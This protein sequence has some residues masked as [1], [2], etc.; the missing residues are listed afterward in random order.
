M[1]IHLFLSPIVFA[2]PAYTNI[3][4]GEKVEGACRHVDSDDDDQSLPS[5][6]ST[7]SELSEFTCDEIS[8]VELCHLLGPAIPEDESK[9]VTIPSGFTRPANLEHSIK[10]D[11]P[12]GFRRIRKAFLNQ[13][14]DFWDKKVLSGT[15]KYKNIA[16]KGW[17]R[18]SDVIGSPTVPKGLKYGDIVG[19]TK[20]TEYLMPKTALVKANMAY[21][22]TT[23]TAYDDHC[24]AIEMMTSNPDVPFGK[25]FIA[26]TKIVVYN[27][28]ANSCV[29]ECSVE[30][31]FPNGPPMAISRQIKHAMKTGSIEVFEKIGS[32]IKNCAVSYGW[33]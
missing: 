18:H 14:N 5:L 27:T 33:V 31:V 1:L 30:T 16:S 10:I 19:A 2:A 7:G 23:I 24:F 8:Q 4:L 26:H 13:D 29:M 9:H 21:E 12:V 11:L 17:D 32:S 15:L 22:T 20:K 28:G 3:K 25:K 6:G